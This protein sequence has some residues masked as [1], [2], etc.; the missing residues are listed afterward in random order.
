MWKKSLQQKFLEINKSSTILEETTNYEVSHSII[1]KL[2][3]SIKYFLIEVAIKAS[4]NSLKA[5]H[6]RVLFWKL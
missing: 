5:T 6:V 1:V 4:L 3:L 2:F